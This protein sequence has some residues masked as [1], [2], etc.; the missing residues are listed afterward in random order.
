M[1][2]TY[3]RGTSTRL[4]QEAPVPIVAVQERIDVPGGAAN[5]AVNAAAL[6]ARAALVAVV[7]ADAEG[8]AVRRTLKE[9][10]VAADDVVEDPV[11]RTL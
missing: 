7:G 6:G 9:R 4:C 2:D 10:G 11:R 8:D 5:T 3:L 1:L